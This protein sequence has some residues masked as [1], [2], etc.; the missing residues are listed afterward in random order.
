MVYVCSR[1]PKCDS[2]VMAYSDTLEPMGSLAGP[3]LRKRRQEAHR[4]L[5][6]LVSEGLMSKRQAYQWLARV[7]SAPGRHAHIGHLGLYY[8]DLVIRES[9]A[10]LERHRT[11]KDK[12]ARKGGG[13]YAASQ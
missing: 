8:C 13:Q 3:E 4:A 2:Y 7:V 11:P 6:R 9:N 12:K 1:Y 10:L 5:A